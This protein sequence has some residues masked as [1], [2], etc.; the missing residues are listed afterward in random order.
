VSKKLGEEDVGANSR[1]WDVELDG[2]ASKPSRLSPAG[3]VSVRTWMGIGAGGCLVFV[4]EILFLVAIVS[5]G[6]PQDREFHAK[7][8]AV[9]QRARGLG[10]GVSNGNRAF[11]YQ[12]GAWF[13]DKE[14]ADWVMP[15]II[16]IIRECQSRGLGGDDLSLDLSGTSVGDDG[17]GLLHSVQGLRFV[18]IRDTN[19]TKDGVDSLRRALPKTQVD[20]WPIYPPGNTQT[21]GARESEVQ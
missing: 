20:A 15:E 10:G 6:T 13:H 7:L 14:V 2:V 19:V 5:R 1:I 3:V 18:R 8:S 11:R 21:A 16:S 17:I 4:A 9:N 12:V